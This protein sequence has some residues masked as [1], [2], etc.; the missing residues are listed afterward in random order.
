MEDSRIGHQ[1]L[2]VVRDDKGCCEICGRVR[3]VPADEKQNRGNSKE[4]KVE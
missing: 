4:V 1:E 3:H 2:L